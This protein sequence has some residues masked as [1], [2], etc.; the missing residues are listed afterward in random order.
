MQEGRQEVGSPAGEEGCWRA[1]RQVQWQ[2][3][4]RRLGA[5][6]CRR[7][8]GARQPGRMQPGRVWPLPAAASNRSWAQR[9]DPAVQIM[10][11][12][13]VRTSERHI[14]HVI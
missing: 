6:Q 13:V 12:E 14:I 1:G 7:L 11:G 3:L 4:C 2:E 5:V 10:R 9:R 8:Q